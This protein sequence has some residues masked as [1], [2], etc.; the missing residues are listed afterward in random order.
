MAMGMMAV[1]TKGMLLEELYQRGL[2]GTEQK[3]ILRPNA[4]PGFTSGG[5]CG[6][7]SQAVGGR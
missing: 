6:W 5:V 3:Q 2:H 1:G 7:L 4:Y